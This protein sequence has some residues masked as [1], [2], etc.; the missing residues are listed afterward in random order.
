MF[1]KMNI[2]EKIKNLRLS[3]LMTQKE[4]AGEVITRNMLS[5]IET[6]VASPSLKTLDYLSERLGV[7][8][9]YLIN[10]EETNEVFYKKYSNYENLITAFKSGE[11][12]ICR[13]IC[14]ECT[15]EFV[16]N[17]ISY[18]LAYSSMTLGISC[19]ESGNLRRACELFEEAVKS[20]ENT[21]F[22]TSAMLLKISA[23]EDIMS[24]ISPTLSFEIPLDRI[25]NEITLNNDITMF[26]SELLDRAS[27]P[28]SEWVNKDYYY[29]LGARK[30][31]NKENYEAAVAIISDIVEENRLP[32]P[33]MYLVMGDYEGCCKSLGDYKNAYDISVAKLQLFER[34]LSQE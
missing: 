24:I 20:A 8:I 6:G 22:D 17:E 26:A 31:I 1:F 5:Q 21:V 16:D 4:L 15:S 32:A 14:K 18:M 7:P 19:F 12:A 27:Y 33:I 34:L 3:K 23:Y 13:D 25:G 9:G 10:D 2:G 11:W 28:E 29:A 30:L